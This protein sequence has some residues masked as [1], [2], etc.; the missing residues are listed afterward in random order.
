MSE[1]IPQLA[2][3]YCNSTIYEDTI[4]IVSYTPT[5]FACVYCIID[6]CSSIYDCMYVYMYVQ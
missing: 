2:I 3:N 1:E 5:M 4:H 6:T